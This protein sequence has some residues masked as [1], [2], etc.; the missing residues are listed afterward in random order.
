MVLLDEIGINEKSIGETI[1]TSFSQEGKPH[2]AA[3]GVQSK[4]EDRLEMKI[5]PNTKTW[6]NI[7]AKRAGVVNITQDVE[8]IAR[9]GL[10]DDFQGGTKTPNFKNA[11]NVDAPYLPEVD[12]IIE[13]EVSEIEKEVVRDKIGTSK[14]RRVTSQVKNIEIFDSH[15]HPIKRSELYLIESSV[16]AS[17]AIESK[18]RGNQESFQNFIE[19]IESYEKKCNKIAPQSDECQFISKILKHVKKRE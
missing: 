8:L 17:K 2:M 12:A 13:F 5:F 14:V 18:N 19:E 4:G 15:P 16:L 6:K 10:P 3:I 11:E 7:R 9:H 1:V